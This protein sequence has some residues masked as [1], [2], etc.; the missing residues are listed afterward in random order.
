MYNITE[1]MKK[2]SKLERRVLNNKG[3]SEIEKTSCVF[4]LSIKQKLERRVLNN[5]GSSEI[6]KTSCVFLLSIKQSMV[7]VSC[8]SVVL[9][10]GVM[11]L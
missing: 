11:V 2:R 9:Y 10:F 6:E 3:S 1:F 4:L 5:K 7:T 8:L